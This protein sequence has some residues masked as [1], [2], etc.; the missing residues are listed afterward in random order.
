MPSRFSDA[1]AELQA[2]LASNEFSVDEEWRKLISRARKLVCDDGFNAAE[3]SLVE[4]LRTTVAKRNGAGEA[5]A[6]VLF[7]GAGEGPNG[8]VV[9]GR[10]ARRLGALKTLRHTYFLKR[11]GAHKIWIVSIPRSFPDWPHNALKG[12]PGQVT[13]RLNDRRER[14]SLED[15]RNLSHASQEA[16]KWVHKAMIVAANPQRG[17]HRSLIAKWFADRNTREADLFAMAGTLNVGLKKIAWTL[18]SALLIYTDSVSERAIQANAGAE[19]FVWEDRLDVVYVEDEFFGHENTLKGLT[20]WARILV[21]EVSH[22]EVGT[23]DH[24]YEWQGMSP[25]AITAAKAIENADSWAW[26]CA[27]CAG[28]LT[29]GVIQYTLAR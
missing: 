9:D 26:F 17:G 15:R 7:E 14:F 29:N 12:D 19:A 1:Y 22:G 5:E 23:K 8:G 4:D 10:M 28:A 27:D 21:H 16:L 6:V 11:F 13:S 18:K 3:A 25:R 2:G 20:N 24:A